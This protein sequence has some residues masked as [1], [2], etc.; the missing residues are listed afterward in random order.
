MVIELWLSSLDNEGMSNEFC[1]DLG[2]KSV[3]NVIK[4]DDYMYNGSY[5]AVSSDLSDKSLKNVMKC[6]SSCMYTGG[7]DAGCSDLG[8]NPTKNVMKG[9]DNYKYNGGFDAVCDVFRCVCV[10]V[11]VCVFGISD[12]VC[13]VFFFHF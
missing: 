7:Y 10:C 4:C 2:N 8:N 12:R 3:K 11:H 6:S 1:S 9:S 5:A 13:F